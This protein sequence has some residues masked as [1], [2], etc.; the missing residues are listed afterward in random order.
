MAGILGAVLVVLFLQS[1]QPGEVLFSNDATLGQMEAGPN[2]LPEAFKGKWSFA[3]WVGMNAPTTGLTISPMLTMLLTPKIFLKVYAPLTLLFV[4]FCAWVFFRQLEFHPAVCI[5]GGLAA[6]LNMHFFSAACWGVGAWNISAGMIFLALAA[7]TTKSIR[8]LWA[9]AILAGLAVGVNLMEGFD[10]GAILSVYVGLFIA[11]QI[12]LAEGP[13]LKRVMAA[14]GTG[15]LVVFFSALIAAQ[16]ILSLVGTQVVGVTGA[17]QD[18]QTKE[19]RWNP[20]TQWS[21]PKLET[22]R[23]IIP[24]IFGYRMTGRITVHDKSSAYWGTVGRDPRITALGGPDS[25]ERTQAL[26]KLTI[27]EVD[28]ENLKNT[29]PRIRADALTSLMHR[30]SAAVRYSGSGEFAGVMVSLL[31]FFGL[32]NSW[33]GAQSPYS[34]RERRTVWFWGGAALFSLMASW[35]RYGF[36]YRW[37]YDLPYVSTIRN[38]IKFMHPFHIAWVI[39]AAYGLEA[40]WRRYLRPVTQS[41]KPLSI[42]FER[43]WTRASL[44]AL[45]VSIVGLIVYVN[46]EPHLI[47]YLTQEGFNADRAIQMA[48]FSVL[49]GTW[50]VFWL[51][52]S[53]A[54]VL[55]IMRGAW[56]GPQMRWAWICLGLIIV[57]DLVRSDLPWIHYFNYEKEYTSNAV[58]DV[59]QDQPYEH[60]VTGRLSPRG[61]G[62]GIGS[63]IGQLYDYWQQNEF[64]YYRIETL[65]FAQWPRIPLL[66]AAYMKNFALHGDDV[67]HCDLWPSERLWE[68]TDTRYIVTSSLVLPL[69]NRCADS[70]HS[71]ASR[72]YLKVMAKPYVG[73]VEDA[74]DMTV[75]SETHGDDTIIEFSNPLPRARLYSNWQTPAN[76]D[77]TLKT[78]VSHDFNPEETVLVSA[79]T[80][81][82][83][84]AGS[85]NANPG[86]VTIAEYQPKYVKLQA[87]ALTP[88]VLLLNDRN[89]PEWKVWIDKKPAPMLRCNYLMRGVY[90]TPGVHT[91]E[92]RF[93]PPLTSLYVTICGWSAGILLSGYLIYSRASA[94]KPVSAPAVPEAPAP[95]QKPAP[96]PMPQLEVAGRGKAKG[97]GAKAKRAGK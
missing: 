67:F 17:G 13:A 33:R 25:P 3:A 34:L 48:G 27:P 94:P 35:G 81:V 28:R 61:L 21:L 24:G 2:H 83:Q 72:S 74:G 32:A 90:L 37:L 31:A 23:V 36:L 71:F 51:L 96:A 86:T 79:E 82:T 5:L 92:F 77:A 18:E 69:L 55:I 54:V 30:L 50:F 8:Q 76:D 66:D 40:L 38:P 91:V 88:S 14:F 46:W 53:I 73:A 42:G 59:L 49:E 22:L 29:D 12:F 84:P 44:I 43:K 20:A 65:D 62:S 56:K 58:V 75:V 64:P 80:P 78:L 87:N 39:L 85:T 10:V 63:Q 15:V 11:C 16:S 9:R 19:Q 95:A 70:K 60:R 68:L 26:E 97:K 41:P 4:G 6:G 93:K 57:F 47:T 1:F 52:V 89:A 45:G 7:L